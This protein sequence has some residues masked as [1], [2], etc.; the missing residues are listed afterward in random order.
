VNKSRGFT[1]IE[2]LIV[3]AI[4]GILA[5][6]AIPN[7]LQAQ[8]RA[9]IARAQ[10]D[11]QAVS[12]AL[13]MYY[14]DSNVYCPD[15]YSGLFFGSSWYVHHSLTTPIDY[16]SSNS[17]VDPMR[18]VDAGVYDRYRYINYKYT[19]VD[20]G[21]INMPDTYAQYR[22]GTSTFV[23]YGEWRMNSCGP[24][25][26][27]GPGDPSAGLWGAT[28]VYDPTNGTISPGDIIRCQKYAK[29]ESNQ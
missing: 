29:M 3:V 5:A 27:F 14:V 11:M 6:I 21:V 9:K 10:A 18:P 7:F 26:T 16:L 12:T 28:L 22:D 1:L 8:I 24:D 4:I 20:A 2:L 15:Y 23:G 13:E 25:R 17:F 19:Y